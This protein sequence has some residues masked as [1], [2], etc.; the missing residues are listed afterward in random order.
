MIVFVF[1]LEHIYRFTWMVRQLQQACPHASLSVSM[2]AVD[3][4]GYNLTGLWLTK[5]RYQYDLS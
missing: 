3:N 5:L 4:D 2:E 1:N